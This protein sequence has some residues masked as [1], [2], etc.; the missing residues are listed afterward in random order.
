MSAAMF[1]L[2]CKVLFFFSISNNRCEGLGRL[3]KF[4]RLR[5]PSFISEVVIL[6]E[7]GRCIF[8]FV[9]L[10]SISRVF[11][12]LHH[13]SSKG[14]LLLLGYAYLPEKQCFPKVTTYTPIYL[15]SP[16]FHPPSKQSSNL[17][18][19]RPV[20][21]MSLMRVGPSPSGELLYLW[22]YC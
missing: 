6:E 5:A 20:L 2:F 21:R 18:H 10:I 4:L 17:P 1:G 16:V 22:Y 19:L 15:K 12:S 8:D 11:L 14:Y 13:Q 9:V 7:G 3:T